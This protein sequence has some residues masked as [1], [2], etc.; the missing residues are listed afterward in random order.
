M[1]LAFSTPASRL[2]APIR[3]ISSSRVMRTSRGPCCRDS[4]SSIAKHMA[5]PTPSSPPRDVPVAFKYSPSMRGMMG[6][7]K[8]SITTLSSFWQ[9]ISMCPWKQMVGLSSKPTLHDGNT[10]RTRGGLLTSNEVLALVDIRLASQLLSSLL[11]ESSNSLVVH[12]LSSLVRSTGNLGE[13]EHVL[14]HGLGLGELL[15]KL[16][17]MST[18]D[19]TATGTDSD[20]TIGISKQNAK[21]QKNNAIVL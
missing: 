19:P 12:G 17:T 8:K 4:S 21:I 13:S 20:R 6:S 16:L 1:Y 15:E 9:T 7:F 5:T 14:P 10:E 2:A 3:P 18:R 11:E